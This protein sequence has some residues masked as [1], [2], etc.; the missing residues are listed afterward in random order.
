MHKINYVNAHKKSM[1]FPFPIFTEIKKYSRAFVE[2]YY[3]EF[4][5]SFIHLESTIKKFPRLNKARLSIG[6][7]SRNSRL[8]VTFCIGLL[9]QIS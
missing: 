2:M 9:Y 6:R 7:F 8:L 4:Y 1:V 3:K 5:L